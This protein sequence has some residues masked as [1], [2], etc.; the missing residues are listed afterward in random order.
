MHELRKREVV[1]LR[2]R[3]Q[4]L[5]VAQVD[6]VAYLSGL[7]TRGQPDVPGLLCDAQAGHFAA[8]EVQ[9]ARDPPAEIERAGGVS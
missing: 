2:E 4:A 9:L 7:V 3:A 5:P 8:V 1:A 6:A